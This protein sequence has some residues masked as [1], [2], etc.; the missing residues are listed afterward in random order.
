MKVAHKKNQNPLTKLPLS[1][2]SLSPFGIKDQKLRIRGRR[3]R[4]ADHRSA[5]R[6][7][8]LI[9]GIIWI[10]LRRWLWLYWRAYWTLKYWKCR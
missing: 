9:W 5:V 6:N 10:A 7:N 3:S 2:Y 1:T 4:Q 8:K